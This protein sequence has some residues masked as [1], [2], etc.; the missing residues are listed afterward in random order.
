MEFTFIICP[1]LGFLLI[2]MKVHLR[3]KEGSFS[4]FTKKISYDKNGKFCVD[5]EIHGVWGLRVWK[6][7][8]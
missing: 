6:T 2:L 1:F 5:E 4:Q 7:W 3:F 8:M